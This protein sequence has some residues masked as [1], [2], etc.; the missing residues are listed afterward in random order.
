MYVSVPIPQHL[1]KDIQNLLLSAL[2][3]FCVLIHT[4]V[5]PLGGLLFRT[6]EI[7]PNQD[8]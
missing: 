4:L 3:D 8:T 1:G 7:Q 6:S 5:A 2:Y